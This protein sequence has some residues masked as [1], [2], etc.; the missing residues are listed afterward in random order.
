MYN[1]TGTEGAAPRAEVAPRQ[2]FRIRPMD[3]Q[4]SPWAV[5]SRPAG[6]HST[7]RE[8]RH[9]ITLFPLGPGGL[10]LDRGCIHAAAPAKATLARDGKKEGC[11]REGI[12]DAAV[13]LKLARRSFRLA[14]H[15]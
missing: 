13:I 3:T 5:L 10:K 15:T 12:A 11:F 2:G 9:G 14:F 8:R 7:W 4:A 1:K 6:A